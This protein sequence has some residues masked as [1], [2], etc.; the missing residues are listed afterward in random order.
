MLKQRQAKKLIGCLRL[1]VTDQKLSPYSLI[2]AAAIEAL[3]VP[4]ANRSD[5]NWLTLARHALP[6]VCDEESAR[7]PRTRFH[8]VA[9]RRSDGIPPTVNILKRGDP[10]QPIGVA[11]PGALSCV[12]DLQPRLDPMQVKNESARRAYLAHWLSDRKNPLTWRS[13]VNRVWQH[14]FGR[15][16]VDTPSD[17]GRM[18]SLPSHPE[19]LDWLACELRDNG[20]SLKRLHRLIVTSATYRQ[21]VAGNVAA[22]K[23]DVDNRL[24][25]RM[26][27]S[28]LDAES[29]RDA[30]LAISGRLDLTLGGPSVSQSRA[31]PV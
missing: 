1:S 3:A 18:G 12:S 19:L 11:I 6:T 14:H 21:R 28:R 10:S 8:V 5:D 13:I 25:W 2:A 4:E 27:R 16:I 22:E 9:G 7:L 31:R 24:L 20:M 15:G 26:N 30:I 29:L 17:F 23:I